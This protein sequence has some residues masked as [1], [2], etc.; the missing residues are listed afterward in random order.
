MNIKNKYF[1]KIHS[2]GYYEGPLDDIRE[3]EIQ[4]EVSFTPIYEFCQIEDGKVVGLYTSE[5]IFMTNTLLQS[6]SLKQ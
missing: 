2:N 6:V 3:V 1:Y 5:Q 4:S